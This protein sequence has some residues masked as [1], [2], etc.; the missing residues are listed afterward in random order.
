MLSQR[1]DARFALV[2]DGPLRADLERRVEALGVGHAVR[3][4]GGLGGRHL[5]ELFKSADCVCVP[6]RSEPFGMV[7]LEAWASGVPVVATAEGGLREFVNHGRDGFQV[8]PH[9]ASI[10]WGILEVFSDF[11]KAR[12]MG[13]RG[14]RKAEVHFNWDRIAE[15]TER[16]YREVCPEEEAL[17]YNSLRALERSIGHSSFA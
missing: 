1:A 13:R 2:G 17:A 3:F 5:V 12:E 14:R 4:L 16:V 15:Q 10:S 11:G 6:S 7:V 8:E 9:P